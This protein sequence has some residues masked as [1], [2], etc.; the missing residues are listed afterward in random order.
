MRNANQDPNF[1]LYRR[2]R[3]RRRLATNEPQRTVTPDHS[4]AKQLEQ[5]EADELHDKR[6]TREVHDFFAA[7]TRTAANIVS[8]VSAGA[9][10]EA[11]ERLK[12]E[13]QEFLVA[14]LK[15]M[16]IF[17]RSILP[18][19]DQVAEATL[20]TDMR[21][22]VGPALDGFRAEGT[23][24][25]GDKHFGMNPFATDPDAVKEELGRVRGDTPEPAAAEEGQPVAPRIAAER[26]AIEEHLVAELAREVPAEGAT[27]G[28]R[29]GPPA[30]TLDRFKAA[31]KQMV[32]QGLMS[33]D[34]ARAAWRAKLDARGQRSDG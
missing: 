15:R 19:D 29:D 20:D 10:A 24:P 28:D 30:E 33:Q 1:E 23:A 12:R 26:P 9:Q 14:S 7:A 31:L 11:A 32:R 16:N 13:M 18:M 2:E 34:E 3:E 5:V 4:A 8:K 25:V 17:V 21:N 27:D 6:L 22:L